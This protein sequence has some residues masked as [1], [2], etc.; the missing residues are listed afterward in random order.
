M[1]DT[2]PRAQ[3]RAQAAEFAAHRRRQR[4]ADRA[5]GDRAGRFMASIPPSLIFLFRV[6]GLIRYRYL[7]AEE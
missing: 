6:L 3:Q 4:G 5:G 2:G 7:T 1:R